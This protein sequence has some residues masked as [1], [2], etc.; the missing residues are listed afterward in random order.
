MSGRRCAFLVMDNVEG[1]SIDADLGIPPLEA[2]GW[3]VEQVRWRSRE[4]R[5]D[6]FDAVYIGTPWDYPEDVDGFLAVLERI[7]ASRA[8]LVNPLALVRWN[9]P[10]TYLRDLESRG[11]AI[12]PS[13]WREQLAPGELEASFEELKAERIVVKPVVSTNARDT[14][15][16]AREEAARAEPDL[17]RVFEQRALIVQPFIEEVQAEGEY[18]LFYFGSEFSHAILKK[19]KARDFRVQEEHGASIAPVAAPEAALVAVAD[20]ILEQ[21]QPSPAYARCDLVRG[22]D[23]SFLLMELELI[24]PSMYLR[25]HPDAPARFAAAFDAYVKLNGPS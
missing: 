20:G 9:L 23:G 22:P 15:L 3:R 16:L 2:L 4:A 19:P 13:R 18:S 14:F 5:W 7:D 25:M 21:V 17:L 6:E 1:W 24:E 8:V 11:A 10:K 12:V